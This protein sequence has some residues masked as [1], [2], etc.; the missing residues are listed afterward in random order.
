M[1]KFFN[2]TDDG[3]AINAAD[4]ATLLGNGKDSCIGLLKEFHRFDEEISV[5][6][7]W[8]GGTVTGVCRG[9]GSTRFMSLESIYQISDRALHNTKDGVEK[10][11]QDLLDDF[12]Q[13]KEHFK[14]PDKPCLENLKL[15]QLGPSFKSLD[16]K[17]GDVYGPRGLRG[18]SED[19]DELDDNALTGTVSIIK[20]QFDCILYSYLRAKSHH[21]TQFAGKNPCYVSQGNKTLLDLAFFV[22][23]SIPLET[24]DPKE[25]LFDVP[26]NFFNSSKSETVSI[27]SVPQKNATCPIPKNIESCGA[28]TSTL[29]CTVNDERQNVLECCGEVDKMRVRCEESP[30]Y[31]FN[32]A[33]LNM[34]QTLLNLA[35]N[36]RSITNTSLVQDASAENFIIDVFEEFIGCA[37]SIG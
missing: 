29:N 11:V 18:G 12:K 21:A 20:K 15:V 14:I 25:Y 17:D 27:S 22:E 19:W 26:D 6:G 13:Q 2:E 31:A 35:I 28:I 24:A 23:D 16:E 30:F 1:E 5:K 8:Q 33:E 9:W 36:Q 10:C 7:K 34:K 3:F 4:K 37:V 32:L